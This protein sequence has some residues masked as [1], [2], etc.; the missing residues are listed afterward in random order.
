METT[1]LL[2]IA[3]HLDRPKVF[4]VGGSQQFWRSGAFLDDTMS[5][6]PMIH[7]DQATATVDR[8]EHG[9]RNISLVIMESRNEAQR[10]YF[11]RISNNIT[12]MNP[13]VTIGS[14]YLQVTRPGIFDLFDSIRG[15]YEISKTGAC[16]HETVKR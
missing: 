1:L 15:K 9:D 14:N 3:E 2:L 4:V 11:G 16:L 10:G 6:P 12:M 8:Q 7:S 5:H 13:P